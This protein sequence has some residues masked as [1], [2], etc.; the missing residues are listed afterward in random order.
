MPRLKLLLDGHDIKML[1]NLYKTR[2]FINMAIDELHL[3]EFD[4][5]DF[6]SEEAKIWLLWQSQALGI[7]SD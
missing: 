7:P 2:K 5:E 3:Y 1:F 6:G 4:P